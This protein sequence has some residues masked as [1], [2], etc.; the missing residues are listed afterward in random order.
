MGIGSLTHFHITKLEFND[1]VFIILL[2]WLYTLTFT[3][4]LNS[5]LF[6]PLKHEV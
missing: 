6:Q 5:T 1:T 4:I 3:S 2:C